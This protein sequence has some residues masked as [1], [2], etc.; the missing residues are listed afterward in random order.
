MAN[1]TLQDYPEISLLEE[2]VNRKIDF[3]DIFGR[4]GPVHVEIGSGKGTFLVNQAKALEDVYFLGI[5][6]ANKYY[7]AAVDRIGRWNLKNVRII[8]TDAASLIRE[9]IDDASVDWFHIYYPDPWPKKRHKKRRFFSNENILEL[10]R[11]LKPNGVVQFAT[12]HE[13]YYQQVLEV[14]DT[15]KDRIEKIDFTPAVGAKENEFVGTNYERKY[16]VEGRKSYLAA[17]RKFADRTS[18]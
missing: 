13:D 17:I 6:W 2:N 18:A 1:R 5:E 15:V 11:C 8:R 10:L 14:L 9:Y 3:T 12:D 16:I 4:R 7:R